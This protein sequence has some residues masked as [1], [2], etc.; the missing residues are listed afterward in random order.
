MPLTRQDVLSKPSET[1]RNRNCPVCSHT[2]R[3]EIEQMV[4]SVSPSNPILTLDAIADA[5]DISS[6]ALR[7]HALMHTPLALDFSQQSETL[8]VET[9]RAKATA[10]PQAGPPPASENPPSGGAIDETGKETMGGVSDLPA[11]E[12]PGRMGP[13]EV[14]ALASPFAAAATDHSQGILGA[15]PLRNRMT[16][17]VN[18]REGD[19]LLAAANEM[20]T[21]LN[22]IGRK[23][24][25]LASQHSETA[26]AKLV[27]FATTPIVNLYIGTSSELRKNIQAI[28][29]LNTSVNGKEDGANKGL[30]AL[31]AAIAG[32]AP[33]PQSDDGEADP[34]DDAEHS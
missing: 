22:T 23:L 3:A 31:A 11:T 32:N 13:E 4:L 14:R 8:L 30:E 19:M 24:K 17:S 21:T 34:G 33:T 27:A 25:R 26:D 6:Q 20:L 16:D 18:L 5:Y 1:V 12:T 10:D 28:N 29:E 9:F 2:N 7:V 15:T